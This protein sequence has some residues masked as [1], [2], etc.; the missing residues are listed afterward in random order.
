MQITIGSRVTMHFSLKLSDGMLVESSFDDQPLSFV[1]GDGT[2]DKGLELALIGLREGDHQVL[3]L[4]PGQAFGMRDETAVQRV[5]KSR[6]PADMQLEPG[7]I[8]GFSGPDGEELAGAVLELEDQHVKVDFN[9]PLAGREIV[10]ETRIIQV[11]NPPSE[12]AIPGP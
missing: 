10:F 8:V 6:F 1:V 7:Q 9:H 3:T 12:E 11:T 2:L 4:M 5:E